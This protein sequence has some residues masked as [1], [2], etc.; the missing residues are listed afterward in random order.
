[1][2]DALIPKIEGIEILEE[3][4]KGA[5]GVVYRA[6]REGIEYALKYCRLSSSPDESVACAFR[7]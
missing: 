1:M 2:T 7:R 3:I 6:R 4:G 5:Q